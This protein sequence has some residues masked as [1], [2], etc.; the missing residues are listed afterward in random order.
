[1]DIKELKDTLEIRRAFLERK[2]E[3]KKKPHCNGINNNI[4]IETEAKLEEVEKILDLL[5]D[6]KKNIK[7]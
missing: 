1:M 6:I 4:I 7:R 3:S 5:Y 2:L